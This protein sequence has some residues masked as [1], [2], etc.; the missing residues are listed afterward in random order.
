VDFYEVNM[1]QKLVVEAELVGAG[2]AVPV[3]QGLGS[4]PLLLRA[5]EIECLPADLVSTIDVDL[6]LIQ[7]PDDVIHV[8][9]L[10]APRGVTILADPDIVVARFEALQAEVEGEEEQVSAE[11]VEIIARGKKEEEFEE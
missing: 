9:D 4:T 2:V 8:R 10:Q 5:I 6:S 3:S 7:A 11:D 1:A